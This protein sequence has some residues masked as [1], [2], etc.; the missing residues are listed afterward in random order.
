[1]KRLVIAIII[2]VV[3]GAGAWFALKFIRLK[4][5]IEPSSEINRFIIKSNHSS[6]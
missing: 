4:A 6:I 5:K 1:M 2:L 3:V